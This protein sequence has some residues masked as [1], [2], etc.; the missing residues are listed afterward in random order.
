VG[1][2]LEHRLKEGMRRYPRFVGLVMLAVGLGMA[3]WFRHAYMTR[4]EVATEWVMLTPF[5]ILYGLTISIQPSALVLK[6]EFAS[7]A[8]RDKWLNV[9]VFF[10]GLGLGLY[11]NFVVFREWN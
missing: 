5:L 11:L 3:V 8:P 7:A 6:G 2:K 4:A 10:V 1:E 9:V